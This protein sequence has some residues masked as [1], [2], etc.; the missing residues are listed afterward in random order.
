M[1]KK[2]SL[3]LL[4]VALLT[5]CAQQKD[6][7]AGYPRNAKITYKVSSTSQ[8][9]SAYVE[10]TNETGGDTRLENVSLPFSKSIEKKVDYAEIVSITAGSTAVNSLTL[11][12]EIDG[13]V[14]DSKRFD[15]SGGVFGGV[16]YQFE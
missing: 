11:E 6:P 14:K 3:V 2:S 15:E 10:F 16:Y 5:G 7:F 4:S 12:I 8:G 1:L 13:K 9:D